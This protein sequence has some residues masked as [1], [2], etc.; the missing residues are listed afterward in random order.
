MYKLILFFRISD[1]L[2]SGVR[3]GGGLRYYCTGVRETF[4]DIRY[5][6]PRFGETVNL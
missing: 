6:V 4:V 3:G 5:N 1:D 2:V